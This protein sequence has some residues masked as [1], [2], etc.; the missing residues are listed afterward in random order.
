MK[1]NLKKHIEEQRGKLDVQSIKMARTKK[2]VIDLNIEISKN[3]TSKMRRP[4]SRTN[5]ISQNKHTNSV[6]L[7]FDSV[8]EPEHFL[9]SKPNNMSGNTSGRFLINS[10]KRLSFSNRFKDRS[11]DSNLGSTPLHLKT[12]HRLLS[13]DRKLANSLSSVL[14]FVP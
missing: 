11:S 5:S 2:A 10:G 1:E 6:N 13:N 7:Q 9:V 4:I 12:S 8:I 14:T 3:A